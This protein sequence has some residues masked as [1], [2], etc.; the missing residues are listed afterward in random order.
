MRLFHRTEA[1]LG[2]GAEWR[3]FS[4]LWARWDRL[5][6][7][8]GGVRSK[9]LGPFTATLDVNYTTAM[10]NV[11]LYRYDRWEVLTGAVFRIE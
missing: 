7:F 4:G 3:G 1:L 10:S 11:N 5:L 9:L 8:R 2:A 6:R